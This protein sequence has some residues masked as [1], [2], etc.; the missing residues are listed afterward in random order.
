MIRVYWDTM[1]FAY[2]LEAHPEYGPKMQEVQR[3]LARRGVR[4]CTSVFT[5]GEALTYPRKL[6][7]ET[8]VRM[9]MKYFENRENVEIIPFTMRTAENYAKIRA[10]QRVLPAD[11]VHLAS[12]SELEVDLFMTNDRKLQGLHVD[13]IKFITGMDGRFI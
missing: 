13:G 9:L 3:A 8:R 2:L 4:L 10:T 12:A 5:V 6:Q 1:L 11:A 7:D